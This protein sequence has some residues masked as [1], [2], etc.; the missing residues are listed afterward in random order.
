[1]KYL[2]IGDLHFGENSSCEKFNQEVI[3]LINHTIEYAK[4][5]SIEKVIQLGDWFHTRNTI[6]VSTLSYGIQGAQ[7]LNQ[8]FGRDNVYVLVG[9][10]DMY[11][12]NS[13][14]VTSLESIKHLV[15]VVD[16]MTTVDNMLLTPWIVDD[17]HWDAVVNGSKDHDY[18][19]AHLE[20]KDFKMNAEYVM[21]HGASPRELREYK[22]VITGH[23]HTYQEKDNIVY[24]GIPFPVSM[25]EANQDHYFFVFDSETGEL[26]KIAYD[27]I[28]VA[29]IPFDQVDQY[30]EENKDVDPSLMSIRVE[31]PDD[32]E[33]EMLISEIQERLNDLG[34]DRVRIQYKGN[35]AKEIVEMSTGDLEAVDNIDEL[36]LDV[37]KNGTEVSGVDLDLLTELYKTAMNYEGN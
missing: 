2:V 15:T 28:K 5:N 9:N 12:K 21:E 33:D 19:F 36:V 7:L 20:L 8:A 1:M 25:T 24:T 26:E 37:I 14:E 31:F 16:E 3:N 4:E 11:Y 22:K 35:K 17:S 30:L 29:S 27:R 10:H 13:L 34:I 18:L 6:N 32:L 23:Y